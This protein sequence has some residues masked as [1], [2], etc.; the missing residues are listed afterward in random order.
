M[1]YDETTAERVR[2]LLVERPDLHERKMIGAGNTEHTLTGY[3]TYWS[4]RDYLK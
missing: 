1:A 3:L 2:H 4:E